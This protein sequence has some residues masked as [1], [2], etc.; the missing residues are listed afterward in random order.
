MHLTLIPLFI[1]LNSSL[2]FYGNELHLSVQAGS[3]ACVFSK[4]PALLNSIASVLCD[5]LQ[6]IKHSN[7]LETGCVSSALYVVS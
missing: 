6:A 3:Y 7:A 1:L 4:F 2:C 5:S